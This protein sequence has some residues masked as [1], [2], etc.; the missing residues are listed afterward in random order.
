MNEPLSEI[1][2]ER[3]RAI[4]LPVAE[5]ARRAGIAQPVLHRFF[6]R[7]RDLTL[8]TATKLAKYLELDFVPRSG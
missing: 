8:R 2:R 3:M 6:K 1:L 7:E 5:I 4:G